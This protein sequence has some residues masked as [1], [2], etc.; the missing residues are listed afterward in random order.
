MIVRARMTVGCP[1]CSTAALIRGV[2][3]DRIVAAQAQLLELI[4]GEVL[5]HLEQPRVVP[6]RSARGCR[7]PPRRCTS[8]TRRRRPRP[9]AWRAGRRGRAASSGSQSLPQSTLMTFQP[10]PRKMAS[11]S[12]MILPLPRTGPSSRCR[13]QLMTKMRLSSFSRAARR[14]RAE[15]FGLVG[16]AV[17]EEGPDLGVRRLLQAAI[18]E[19]AV[20]AGLVDRHDRPE[21]HRHRRELPE[22]GHQPGMRIG[23]QAPALGAAP[24]GSSAAA[25]R[26]SRPSRNARA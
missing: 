20:E 1:L 13:L 22:V 12:W 24:G 11:S 25:R 7:R 2:D 17:A 26:V 18:F 3:L 10:A 5:D 15:R 23:R 4:V 21:A 6:R 8:D 9:C 19:V 16:L 14:D